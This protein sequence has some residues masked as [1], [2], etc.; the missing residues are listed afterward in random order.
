MSCYRYFGLQPGEESSI[1]NKMGKWWHTKLAEF[2][3][4]EQN[5]DRKVEVRESL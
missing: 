4:I 1:E 3:E 2:F 5:M